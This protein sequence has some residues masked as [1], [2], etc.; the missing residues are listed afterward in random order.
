[1][2]PVSYASVP[3]VSAEDLSSVA[4][5]FRRDQS[6]DEAKSGGG[7][8]S[9]VAKWAMAAVTVAALGGGAAVMRRDEMG[10][11][12]IAENVWETLAKTRAIGSAP[13]APTRRDPEDS[14]WNEDA[15]RGVA[16]SGARPPPFFHAALS[17]VDAFFAS[18]SRADENLRNWR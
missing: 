7:R 13:S 6:D 10:A 4:P 1:M 12:G 3:A 8:T 14:D 2:S 5:T 11:G 18:R 9:K 16:G 17:I 15:N